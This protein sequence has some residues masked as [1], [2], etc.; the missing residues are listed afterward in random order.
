VEELGNGDRPVAELTRKLRL[1][2]PAVSRHLRL[3][4]QAGLV[5][6]QPVGARHLCR[7]RSDGAA[8]VRGYMQR[9]REDATTPYRQAAA[10]TSRPRRRT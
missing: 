7:L 9:V 1:S 2:Q 10:N 8:A 6:S 4:R 5:D 3:L